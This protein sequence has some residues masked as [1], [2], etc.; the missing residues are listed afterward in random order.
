M[1][2]VTAVID[3]TTVKLD[4]RNWEAGRKMLMER[5]GATVLF[6]AA[7]VA[8]NYREAQSKKR[9]GRCVVM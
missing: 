9:R 1:G 5:E 6:V 4:E 7:V 3:K 2:A 8:E